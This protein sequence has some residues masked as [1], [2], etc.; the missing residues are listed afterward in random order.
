[1]GHVPV[2]AGPVGRDVTR[3]ARCRKL[4]VCLIIRAPDIRSSAATDR[5]PV[6]RCPSSSGEH[7]VRGTVRAAESQRGVWRGRGPPISVVTV[8]RYEG[9]AR[10]SVVAKVDL[11]AGHPTVAVAVDGR[12]ASQRKP[13]AGREEQPAASAACWVQSDGPQGHPAHL[14]AGVLTATG[15]SG[16]WRGRVCCRQRLSGGLRRHIPAKSRRGVKIR[17]RAPVARRQP[18]RRDSEGGALRSDGASHGATRRVGWS[19]SSGRGSEG[20]AASSGGRLVHVPQRA[21]SNGQ[22]HSRAAGR[23]RRVG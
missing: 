23:P 3:H 19:S 12:G 10:R 7:V 8:R 2:Q 4:S 9:V 17:P 6:R 22:G 14:G 21:H 5:L 1:M 11:G 18:R 16:C 15:T 13:A 20:A